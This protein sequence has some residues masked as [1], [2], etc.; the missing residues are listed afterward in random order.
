MKMQKSYEMSI[1]RI[2]RLKASAHKRPHGTR[3]R[4]IG[5]C[6][7][8]LCRAA[9]SRY[10]TQRD[11]A[12]RAGEP[13]DILVSSDAARA[14]LARLSAAGVGYKSVG[15]AGSVA[16]SVLAEI[17]QGR[18]PQ[19]RRSTE[20]K[21]LA[22]DEGAVAGNGL[23]PAGPT[24]KILDGLIADG[25]TKTQLA[26]W[27]GWKASIQLNRQRITAASAAKVRRMAENLAAGRLRRER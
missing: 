23:V 27:C 5:G 15:A 18:R 7:C 14:H 8:M 21:I 10:N 26:K 6:K 12:R 1:R 4:Y 11:A 25:Y 16:I 2:A 3:A 13:A 17:R 9:N 19:I 24:W 22:V 20:R